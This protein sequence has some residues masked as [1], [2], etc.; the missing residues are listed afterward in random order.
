MLKTEHLSEILTRDLVQIV[1]MF[2]M[3]VAVMGVTNNYRG[4]ILW[5]IDLPCL[6]GLPP[7]STCNLAARFNLMILRHQGQELALAVPQVGQLITCKINRMPRLSKQAIPD[8]LEKCVEGIYQVSQSADML[9]L[10][11]ARLFDLLSK[12]PLQDL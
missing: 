1:P 8:I 12:N 5:V 3:P 2:D 7:L 9:V 11:T 6:L 4:E 10:D